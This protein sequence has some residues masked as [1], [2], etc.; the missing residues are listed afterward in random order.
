MTSKFKNLFNTLVISFPYFVNRLTFHFLII[1]NYTFVSG[2]KLNQ[3]N[4]S[5]SCYTHHLSLWTRKLR[6]EKHADSTYKT[7]HIS[8]SL[9]LSKITIRTRLRLHGGV[10]GWQKDHVWVS[11]SPGQ[12]SRVSR[13]FW[14]I[15]LNV[16]IFRSPW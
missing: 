8:P 9:S 6:Q 15:L 16:S 7:K 1:V 10:N 11:S 3:Y 14:I 5:S 12:R 4:S 2:V 13:E